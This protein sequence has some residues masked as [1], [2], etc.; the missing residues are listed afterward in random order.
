[1]TDCL[2]VSSYV[3]GNRVEYA[4]GVWRYEDGT[5]YDGRPMRPCPRCGRGPTPDD[6]DACLGNIPGTFSACCG[7][8]VHRPI[9]KSMIPIC[10]SVWRWAGRM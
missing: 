1:M 6:H 10:P 5:P 9:F 3:L 2:H 4:N 7:H 8:G